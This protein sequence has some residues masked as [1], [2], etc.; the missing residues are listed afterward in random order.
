MKKKL[1]SLAVV[2][3]LAGGMSAAQAV[4]VNSDGLGQVLLYPFYSVESGND[5]YVT[6]VNTTDATKAVKVRFLEGMNSQEVLDFNLYLSPRDVW[7]GVI[8][9]VD[10][11]AAVLRTPDTS[12]TVPAIPEAGVAFRN[13]QYSADSVSGLERTR[14]GYLELIEMGEVVN[15]GTFTPANWAKHSNGVPANCAAIRQAWQGGGAW[16]VDRT[17]AIEPADGGLYGSGVLINVAEGTAVAYDAT[18][19]DNFWRPGTSEHSDPGNTLPSL[20][21]AQ[22]NADVIAGPEVIRAGF[23]GARQ[24]IDAVSATMMHSTIANDFILDA[25]LNASTDWVVNFPTK[26]FY[27]NLGTPVGG[28]FSVAQPFTAGWSRTASRAC[29]SVTFDYWDREETPRTP[30]GIDFSPTPDRDPF[31]LCTE[32]NVLT[33]NNTSALGASGR[34]GSNLDVDFDNGWLEMGLTGTGRVIEGFDRESEFVD[35]DFNGLPVIGFA[36]QKY[37]NGDVGGLLS[38]YMGLTNHKGTRAIQ[39]FLVD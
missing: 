6:V 13:F 24:G 38:N 31:A 16:A 34:I 37:V 35:I 5:T 36:V 20:A 25:G 3:A 29:E 28:V 22:P 1:V 8:T 4:H 17:R 11:G 7:V 18:A 33:F 10:D 9:A 32:V 30:E 15:D 19:L 2:T 14:E 39:S 12:C 27:T 21:S 26:R 23:F